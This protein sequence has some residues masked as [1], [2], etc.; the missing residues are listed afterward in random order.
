MTIVGNAEDENAIVVNSCCGQCSGQTSISVGCRGHTRPSYTVRYSA[1]THTDTVTPHQS[2][3]RRIM[4]V[5]SFVRMLVLVLLAQRC[6]N[7]KIDI[8]V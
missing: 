7:E 6:S 3:H 8:A 2:G 5:T 4:V 1:I